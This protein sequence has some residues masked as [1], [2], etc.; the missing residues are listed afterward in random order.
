VN[1]DRRS[2]HVLTGRAE[3]GSSLKI[4]A[5]APVKKG[6]Q[7]LIAYGL[8]TTG[9]HRFIQDYGFLDPDPRANAAVALALQPGGGGSRGGLALSESERLE[10]L[11][12]LAETTVEE[13]ERLLEEGGMDGGEELAVRFRVGI[14]RALLDAA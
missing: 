2:P 5:G 10:T 7:I 13:D 14:K 6:A 11:A 4:V 9:Q 3:A 8:P 1:H 12:R